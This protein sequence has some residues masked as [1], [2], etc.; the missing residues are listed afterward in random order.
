MSVTLEYKTDRLFMPIWTLQV[1]MSS[2]G[3]DCEESN[4]QTAHFMS[5]TSDRKTDKLFMPMHFADLSSV[6]SV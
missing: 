5:M 4:A 2:F 6:E 1:C 3:P